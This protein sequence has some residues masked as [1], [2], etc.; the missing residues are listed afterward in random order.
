MIVRFDGKE[1]L[2]M[3]RGKKMVFVGDSLNRNMWQSLICLLR[4]SV[5]DQNRLSQVSERRLF[6]KE[7]FYAF[8]FKVNLISKFRAI[9]FSSNKSTE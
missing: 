3:L 6:R 8:E 1:M 9:Q 5:S 2:E 4:M 7:G